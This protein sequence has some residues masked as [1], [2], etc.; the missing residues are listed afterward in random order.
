[1]IEGMRQ[2]LAEYKA[3]RAKTRAALEGLAA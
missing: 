1:V 2:K 3:Q